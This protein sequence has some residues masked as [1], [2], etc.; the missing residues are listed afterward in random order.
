MKLTEFT[1]TKKSG[2]ES[3]RVI[4]AQVVPNKFLGGIEVTELDPEALAAFAIEYDA[5]DDAFKASLAQLLEKYEL[6]T[7]KVFD[8]AN[9]T[10]TTYEFI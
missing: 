8:P 1:Y 4:V 2:A 5:L 7:Y 6:P 9:I 3:N 10:N